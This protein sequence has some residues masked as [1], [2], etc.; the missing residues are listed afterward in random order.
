MVMKLLRTVTQG[1]NVVSAPLDYWRA[2]HN[3][4]FNFMRIEIMKWEISIFCEF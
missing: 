4:P 1:N 2:K 3:S